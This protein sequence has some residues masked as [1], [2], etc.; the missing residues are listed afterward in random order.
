MKS[1]IRFNKPITFALLQTYLA[2]MA[3]DSLTLDYFTELTTFKEG[4]YREV[5]NLIKDMINDL[6]LKTNLLRLETKMSNNKTEYVTYRYEFTSTDSYDFEIPEDLSEEKR[7]TY[8]PVVT[9][10]KL[11]KKHYVSWDRLTKY[12]PTITPKVFMNLII[13][14]KNVIGEELYKNV[15]QSYVIEEIE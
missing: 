10:L 8:L 7:I 9:Y 6:K 2:L 4:T 12:I 1:Q 5:M 13:G 11:K 15:L 3:G 14:L